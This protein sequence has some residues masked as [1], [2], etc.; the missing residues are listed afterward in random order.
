M[1]GVVLTGAVAHSEPTAPAESRWHLFNDFAV[2][3]I[4]TAEA[5][6]FNAAWKMPSVL[7]YQLKTANN[8]S[9]TDW[10]TNLDTSILYQGLT[11][12][13]HACFVMRWRLTRVQL[14]SREQNVQGARDR[15]GDAQRPDD[16]R[17]GHR[18]CGT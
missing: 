10:K 15:S 14:G 3:P 2:R 13:Y 7:L 16:C 5:F 4:S 12:A 6:T 18:I 17:A 8:K 11:Y 9:T 1:R